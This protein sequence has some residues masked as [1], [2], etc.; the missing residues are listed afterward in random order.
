M[1]PRIV[2]NLA[3][4]EHNLNEVLTR[5]QRN[6]ITRSFLVVKVLAGEKQIV[7]K[8]AKYDFEYLADSRLLNLRKFRDIPKKKALLRLPM[9]SEISETIR[10]ADLSLNSEISTI[11]LLNQ[12]AIEQGKIHEILLMF[13]LGDLREGIYYTDPYLPVV[14][15]IL[16]LPAIR[17]VG[18]GTNLTCFGG[19]IPTPAILSR[20]VNIKEAIDAEFHFPL[21]IISGGNSSS[22]YLFDD[23]GLPPEINSLRYGEIV[24]MGRET[25]YGTLLKG[26]YPDIFTLEAQLIECQVKPS[27]PDGETGMN[28]FGVKTSFIDKGPMRRGILAIG[29]QDVQ[30]ENL[31]PRDKDVFIVGGSSDHLIVDLSRTNYHLGDILQFDVNYPGLLHLMNSPYVKKEMQ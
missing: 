5:C 10:D 31:S 21:D 3:K 28:S 18:I 9:P 24:F 15:E 11:R 16:S 13:D 8:L 22:F 17:L 1:Y 12:A 23:P 30:L 29:K 19:L 20:L 6:R 7:E 25:A 4:L 14:K 27:L 26:L 2:T